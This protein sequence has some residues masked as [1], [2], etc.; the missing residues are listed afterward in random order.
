MRFNLVVIEPK[1]YP[2]GHFFDDCVRLVQCGLEGLGHDVTLSISRIL[3]D[4]INV[5]WGVHLQDINTVQAIADAGPYIAIQ[6][7]VMREGGLNAWRNQTQLEEVYM[8]FLCNTVA[9]WD[10]KPTCVSVL[11]RMG[12]PVHLLPF[13]YHPQLEDLPR[14][15]NKDVDFTFFGSVTPHRA[16]LIDT[17]KRA[18][19]RVDVMFDTRKYFRDDLLART[20]VHLAPLQSLELNQFSGQRVCYLLNNRG[21][22][23][24]ER[25]SDQEWLEHCFE[26]ASTEAFADICLQ[27]LHRADREQLAA[28]YF[29]RYREMRLEDGMQRLLDESLG[30]QLSGVAVPHFGGQCLE[31]ATGSIEQA[32]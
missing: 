21:L 29:D 2:H 17:L 27:T 25:S 32:T 9:I 3:T 11:K 10:G 31:Q 30:N 24:V 19:G 14:K 23:V 5:I 22:C 8:P 1:G 15:A 12:L 6:S 13:G 28:T 7:E 20:K 4:R 16:K 18:G 26:T